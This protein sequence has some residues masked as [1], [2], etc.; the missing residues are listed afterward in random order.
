M[1]KFYL[2]VAAALLIAILAVVVR[3]HNGEIGTLLALCGCCL[4]GGLALTFLSPIL[5]F[6]RTLQRLGSL[7][8]D[9]LAIL[10]KVTGVALTTEIAANVCIDAGNGALAKSL[11]MLSAAVIL[12]LSLPMFQALLDLVERI[13]GGI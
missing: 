1:D 8:G 9:M 5:S 2:A 12:Y 4:I 6:L 3:R 11:Q 13:V 10:L 7:N